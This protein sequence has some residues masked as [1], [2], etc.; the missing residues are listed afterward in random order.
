MLQTRDGYLWLGTKGG[1]CRVSTACDLRPSTIATKAQ[2]RESEVWALA[3]GT[4]MAASGS[5]RTAEASVGSRTESLR[6]TR[7]QMASSATTCRSMLADRER[8]KRVDW[9][10][11]RAQPVPAWTLRDLHLEA[12][13][14][15]SRACEVCYRDTDGSLWIGTVRGSVYRLADGRVQVLRLEGDCAARR[16]VVDGARSRERN[17]AGHARR[18]VQDRRRAD[19]GDITADDGLAS[20]R[21]RSIMLAAD[22]AAV[23]RSPRTA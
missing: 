9:N 4:L 5:A 19:G 16:S 22:G 12:G 23:D 7:R 20:N 10:G 1:V 8:W 14:S 11:S 13:R 3:D 18:V 6:S 15:C 2:L 21:M 17:V